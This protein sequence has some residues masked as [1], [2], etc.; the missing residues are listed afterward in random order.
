M[1]TRLLSAGGLC[2]AR[3]LGGLARTDGTRTPYGVFFRSEN[4]DT[5]TPAGWQRLYELSIR[6]VIDL[7]QPVER[8]QHGYQA[9]DRMTAKHVDHDGFD[10]NPDFW[11]DY[12]E[13][14]LVGTALY[15]LPHVTRLPKRSAA[16]LTAIAQATDGAVLFHCAGGRDRTG[17]IAMLLLTIAGV[18]PEAIV[19]DYLESVRNASALATARG[20]PNNEPECEEICHQNGTTTEGA[21]RDTLAGL[22]LD[23]VLTLLND[24]HRTTLTTWHGSMPAIGT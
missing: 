17:I 19:D 22:D 4:L 15:Y 14:G 16:V 3:D 13:N 8:E 11:V 18:E 10:D 5:V 6:T 12:W 23:P 21:F 7:R 9:P 20:R 24:E 2:N 1:E